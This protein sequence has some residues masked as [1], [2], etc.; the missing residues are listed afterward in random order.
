MTSLYKL[1]ADDLEVVLTLTRF[2]TLSSAA[3]R[4]G[5][6]GSTVF[7]SLQRIERGMQQR[8]FARSRTGYLP[9]E[10][11][12]S[13]IEHAEQ[14]EA[15]MEAARSVAQTTSTGVAGTVRI[16]TTDTLLRGLVVPALQPLEALHPQLVF[17]LH[18]SNELTSLA[19]RDAD[20]AVRATRRPPADLV[21]K[22]VGPI[23][24]AL[25]AAKRRTQQIRYEDVERG[26]VRWI[27]PDDALPDHPSVL[28]RKKHFPKAAI[29]Y[30]V[31]SFLSVLDLVALGLGVGMLPVFLARGRADVV[32]ISEP[33]EACETEL[34]LLTHR[35]SRHLRRVATVFRHLS[36]A[37]EL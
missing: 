1:S 15:Q 16:S 12:L 8:L 24:V 23:Q 18:A 36:T 6:D 28:W 5:C 4:L 22:K 20:I 13:L 10:L 2:N 26:S 7:R 32:Q 3:E 35:E 34:W 31:N 27:C 33:I 29:H 17:E 19:R 21:G 14:I 11:A 9:T 37:L 30:K 25:F